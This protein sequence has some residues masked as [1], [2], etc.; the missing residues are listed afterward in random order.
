MKSAWR[1]EEGL[2]GLR[3]SRR[4]RTFSFPMKQKQTNAA[5]QLPSAALPLP[6]RPTLRHPSQ[7]QATS[8]IARSG[9]NNG[10][11]KSRDRS[12]CFDP[13]FGLNALQN[14]HSPNVAHQASPT[15]LDSIHPALRNSP[16]I[17]HMAYRYTSQARTQ[18]QNI[19]KSPSSLDLRR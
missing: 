8:D 7:K 12:F 3:G 14:L 6:N 18:H 16:E 5:S 2:E 15:F 1:R 9:D 13:K 4:F 17:G 19:R 10:S 11:R